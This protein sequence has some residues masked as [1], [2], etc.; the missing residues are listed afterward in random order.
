MNPRV[1]LKQG[2]EKPLLARHPWIFSG[3]IARVEEAADGET[4]D[5]VDASAR[6]LARG[7]Y[8][9]HS[10]IAVRVWTWDDE[11]VDRAFLRA[12]L[13]RAL[14]A[15]TSSIDP[16]ST[17]AFRV[18]NAESDFLPG[19]VADR[20]D[21]FV[22]LQFLTLGMEKKKAEIVELI[23]ELL[24]PRGIYER[25][26]VEVREK[27]GLLPAAGVLQ[28]EPPPAS[29]VVREN[30]LEFLVDVKAGHKTGFYLDQSENR[31]RVAQI[32]ASIQKPGQPS[33]ILNVFSYTGAFSVYVC[34]TNNNARVINL[35][36]SRDA[37]EMAKQNM[38][39]N[40]CEERGEFVEA[41]AF[42]M[43]RR[44]RDMGKTFDAIILD[45]P[46]FVHAQSQLQS[47]LRG[48]K[49]INLLA[50]K[51]LKAGGTLCTF[52]CSGQVGAELYQKVI[53]EAAL[54]ARR[55]AQV[56]AKLLQAPDHPILLSFPES[57]YLKGLV[58]RV[59]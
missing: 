17:N 26:D 25:S 24:Q 39:L 50:F 41:D 12:R 9:S 43:L 46:K 48:Y 5:I 16:H 54:D 11:P 6:W 21:E 30:G 57:E 45:P 13:K 59:I 15:R 28:G 4:V 52:S 29:I 33:E 40:Q 58:C 37:L 36:A 32:L 23:G 19:L 55:D 49:D 31:K 2:K 8:N 22:V 34:Q 14:A 51:L 35:D 7:Y 53:F 42:M 47:G 18:V 44:Y 56:V 20:Y 27:E 38:R 10:Q 1:V 3:A